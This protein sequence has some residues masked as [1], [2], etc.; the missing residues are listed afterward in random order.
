MKNVLKLG[1][2]KFGGKDSDQFKF[3]KESVMDYTYEATKKFFI[4]NSGQ[5]GIFERCPCSAN[6]RHGWTE[7]LDCSGSGF[8]DRKKKE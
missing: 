6:L 2:F 7:C 3:F 4:T 5:G 8:K 1:E